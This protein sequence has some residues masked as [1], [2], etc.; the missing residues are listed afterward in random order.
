MAA[1]Q[2]NRDNML[3][4]GGENLIDLIAKPMDGQDE[5]LFS[6]HAGGSPYN[7]AIALARL[8]QN[9][10]FLSP[11][12]KDNFADLL[13]EP[14]IKAGVKQLIKK[15]VKAPTSLAI[16][17]IAMGG[18]AN[19]QF[20]RQA[21]RA[22]TFDSLAANLPKKIE[23]FHIGGF[24]AIEEK[25][26]K[27]WCKIANIALK[28]QA[29]ISIDANVRPTLVENFQDYKKRLEEFFAISHIIKCSS[30]DLFML[31]RT[32]TITQ[33]VDHLFNH[34]NCALIIVTMGEKGSLAFTRSAKARADIYIGEKF[35]DSVGAG[36]S[37]MAG[38]I[39]KIN[40]MNALNKEKLS[41]LNEKELSNILTYGAVVAGLNCEYYGCHPP[42]KKKVQKALRGK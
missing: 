10:G 21:D 26:Q 42:T 23:L 1:G 18:N 12:S 33:H 38:I 24:C 13:I 5:L 32:K 39:A 8:G 15:R 25:D 40:E 3:V 41:L 37:M 17:N 7:L 11:F 30:E 14:M 29:I 6:A 36:D 22:F 16:V 4:I 34:E 2:Q 27:I 35:A 28:K 19:Y 20:Y 9:T 31:D